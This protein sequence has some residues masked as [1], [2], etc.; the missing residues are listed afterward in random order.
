MIPLLPYCISPLPH[1]PMIPLPHYPTVPRHSSPSPRGPR[2]PRCPLPRPGDLTCCPLPVGPCPDGELQPGEGR[3]IPQGVRGARNI[4]SPACH[5][6]HVTC[7][8]CPTCPMP[9][10]PPLAFGGNRDSPNPHPRGPLLPHGSPE[11]SQ[12]TPVSPGELSQRSLC[13]GIGRWEELREEG[14][15]GTGTSP[16]HTWG[17]GTSPGHSL[18]WNPTPG[19]LPTPRWALS[20]PVGLGGLRAL[21]GVGTGLR[22]PSLGL[23]PC[24]GRAEP[25]PGLLPRGSLVLLSRSQ[26][27]LVLLS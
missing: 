7:V 13:P 2:V 25:E 18:G 14:S 4:P 23:A 11:P 16:G 21:L 3:G 6:C 12:V 10:I 22:S 26:G 9:W 19:T 8:T 27:S 20:V 1:C 24:P 5:L 15:P 17:T